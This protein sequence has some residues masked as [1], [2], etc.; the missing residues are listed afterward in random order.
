LSPIQGQ[1]I[2]RKVTLDASRSTLTRECIV[3]VA[4]DLVDRAGLEGLSMRKLGAALRVEAMA[5]YHHF[6]SKERLLE[7]VVERLMAELGT[8]SDEGADWLGVLRSM[9]HAYRA[10]ARRHPR[11]FT[12]LIRSD[13]LVKTHLDAV[14]AT[15]SA[16][17]FDPVLSALI[18]H[19]VDCY[20]TG[21]ALAEAIRA[22]GGTE[23][24]SAADEIFETGL[25]LVLDRLRALPRQ[26]SAR[27]NPR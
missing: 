7:A 5:L 9:A 24:A 19:V 27:R 11:A 26:V 8:A 18:L 14:R 20:A 10:L 1:I 12:L 21:A 15:L 6:G 22:A 13:P 4:L 23:P 25:A 2:H 3:D 16:A 17:G